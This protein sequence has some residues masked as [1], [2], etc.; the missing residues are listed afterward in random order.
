MPGHVYPQMA[1]KYTN[2]REHSASAVWVEVCGTYLADP[3]LLQHM[4]LTGH[5]RLH[6]STRVVCGAILFIN[7]SKYQS[8]YKRLPCVPDWERK[9]VKFSSQL[10]MK[11]SRI[12]NRQF[13]SYLCWPGRALKYTRIKSQFGVKQSEGLQF[14]FR[15]PSRSFFSSRERDGDD[16]NVH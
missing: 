13:P 16:G 6:Y 11:K 3:S 7:F 8:A 12:P 5:R 2:K 9:G 14:G 10:I 15:L 1:C 4:H